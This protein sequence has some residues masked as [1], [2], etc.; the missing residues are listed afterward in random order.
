MAVQLPLMSLSPW[1]TLLEVAVDG[2][3][4]IPLNR[5]Q[6]TV[7]RDLIKGMNF[8]VVWAQLLNHWFQLSRVYYKVTSPRKWIWLFSG[9]RTF[10]L[11]LYMGV[12][13]WHAVQ[14]VWLIA[15]ISVCTV[16]LAYCFR[17]NN[18][19]MLI[20]IGCRNWGKP[21]TFW[22]SSFASVLWWVD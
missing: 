5:E 10:N 19:I 12:C 2:L 16:L 13:G 18:C 17:I 21:G 15:F 22:G 3:C 6:R 7:R 4:Q 1:K 20:S 8:Q 11:S 14:S 9:I